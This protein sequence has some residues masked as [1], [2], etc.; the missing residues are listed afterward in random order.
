MK[1]AIVRINELIAT[2]LIF[3]VVIGLAARLSSIDAQAVGAPAAGNAA[4]YL[5]HIPHYLSHSIVPSNG[6]GAI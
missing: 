6:Y 4:H 5:S 2:A 3:G 1:A